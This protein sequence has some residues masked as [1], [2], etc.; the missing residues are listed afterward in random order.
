ME[1][2]GN[3]P[4]E[5]PFDPFSVMLFKALQVVA[6]LFFI[7]LLAMN[8]ETKEGKIDTKAEYIITLSWPDSHPDDI[9]LYAEDPLGNIVW[10]HE[11]EAGFMV[12]DRDD[13]GGL[14]NSITV[15][16]RKV[17]NPIRQETISIRGILAGEYTVNVN[18]YLA[19]QPAPVPVTVKIEKV[20]PHVEVVSYDTV[21][22]DHMGQEKTAARFKIAA[23]GDILDVNHRDKSLI[24][25]TRSVRRSNSAK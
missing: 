20:N 22:L 3:Y 1:T 4:L 9:D 24:Q 11:R 10:Y 16:G 15:N 18:Y 17:A 19:T 5:K 13:R 7:A 12:L 21:M 14:N 23:N 6:F 25:L 8:P 2:F